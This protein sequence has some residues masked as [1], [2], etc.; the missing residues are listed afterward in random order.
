MNVHEIPS[1][2]PSSQWSTEKTDYH[3]SEGLVTGAYL[4]CFLLLV[5]VLPGSRFLLQN[6][7]P[8]VRTDELNAV[9]ILRS[10]CH[11]KT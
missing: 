8:L 7:P 11:R 1:G 9:D 2:N 5:Y 4:S 10:N 6:N 3:F